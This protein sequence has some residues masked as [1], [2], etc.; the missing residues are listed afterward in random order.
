MLQNQKKRCVCNRSTTLPLCDGSHHS[1]VWSCA[2]VEVEVELLVAASPSLINFAE[3]LAHRLGGQATHKS[4]QMSA[5]RLIR[6]IDAQVPRPAPHLSADLTLNLVIDAPRS[7]IAPLT[8]AGEVIISLENVEPS[9]LWQTIKALSQA[10]SS[11]LK[12]PHWEA[13]TLP[14]IFLSHA[15]ADEPLL[16]PVIQ[17]LRE[18]Y[19]LKVFVCVD[20]LKAGGRWYDEIQEALEQSS[21]LIITLSKALVNSTFCAYE[22]GFAHGKGIPT[23]ALSLDGT[24]PPL[25]MAHLQALD[26]PRRQAIHPWLTEE[27]LLLQLILSMIDQVNQ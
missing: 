10:P 27:E 9:E 20:S 15:I 23:L 26:L 19:G 21:V 14:S 25:Y 4:T 11:W 22:I 1:T 18:L 13:K 8:Q 24:P 3:R 7:L 16:I 2:E 5:R 12:Q 6:L 17:H